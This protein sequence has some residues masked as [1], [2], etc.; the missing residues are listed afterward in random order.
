LRL[1]GLPNLLDARAQTFAFVGSGGARFRAR[2]AAPVPPQL[3]ASITTAPISVRQ[4]VCARNVR[5]I[6]AG[7]SSLP[8]SSR[9]P[10]SSALTTFRPLQF[11]AAGSHRFVGQ[12]PKTAG[13]HAPRVLATF[14]TED[15]T[16]GAGRRFGRAEIKLRTKPFEI[17]RAAFFL[18]F[19]LDH[20]S[21]HEHRFCE[22]RRT[23]ARGG[24]HSYCLGR[25][26]GSLLNLWSHLRGTRPRSYWICFAREGTIPT[27]MNFS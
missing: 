27:H 16:L 24:G 26:N 21:H 18:P 13:E 17:G 12:P 22:S 8:F 23:D 7:P 19:K 5:R 11:H 25:E 1:R 4:N 6:D 10:R 14:S 2:K 15:A 9:R 20:E 3:P